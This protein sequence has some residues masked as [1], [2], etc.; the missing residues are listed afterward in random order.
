MLAGGRRA[1]NAR[2]IV[3]G[4]HLGQLLVRIASTKLLGAERRPASSRHVRC[5]RP[6]AT[7]RTPAGSGPT[8]RLRTAVGPLP[9]LAPRCPGGQAAPV[10]RRR[11]APTRAGTIWAVLITT[12][13]PHPAEHER[14]V[15]GVSLR[16]DAGTDW[17][18]GLG[19]PGCERAARR[20]VSFGE[21]HAYQRCHYI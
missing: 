16:G 12:A 11:G 10:L 1:W 8:G 13:A 15:A 4:W 14:V 19:S 3:T 9:G 18:C 7:R 20:G 21:A 6:T 2:K 17:G 5:P